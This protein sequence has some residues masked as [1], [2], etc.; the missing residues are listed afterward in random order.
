MSR[1][2][3]LDIDPTPA[4]IG[5]SVFR[6][7]ILIPTYDNPHT[8]RA[9]VEQAKTVVSDILVI[10]DGSG[11]ETR[12]LV[13]RLAEEGWARV[14]HR[15]QNGGKGAAVKTGFE[16]ASELGFTHALQIDADG[17]HSMHD[18][19][20]FLEAARAEPGALILGQPEYD[21][22]APIGRMIGRRITIFWTRMET[23]GDVIGDPLCGFRV[24][25]VELARRCATGTGDRMDFD[26]EIAVKIA[27]TGAP[28]VRLRTSVRYISRADGGVS[29]FRLWR[30]NLLISW[31]HTRLMW[32]RMMY[33][34]FR[35]PLTLPPSS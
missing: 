31:M 35:R 22:S 14:R 32:R 15:R 34:L 27:W 12:A 23:G 17:Q 19:P 30:D 26:P 8:I 13:A 29:H 24:Y 2:A 4:Q 33:R 18:I 6:P 11:P 10:D 7:C 20:R 28:I 9:V 5:G 25:P 21:A 1:F 3:G 16:F